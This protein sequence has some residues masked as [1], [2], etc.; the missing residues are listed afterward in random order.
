MTTTKTGGLTTRGKIVLA[1]IVVLILGVLYFSFQDKINSFAGKTKSGGVIKIGVVTWPG[2]AAGQYMNNGFEP[3]MECRFYKD[4][5]IQVQFV[6]LDDF[7]ASRKAFEAGEVDLLWCTVDA[8][9]TEM[10]RQGTMALSNPKFLFQ[11]DWSRG[12]DAIVVDLSV[13]KISDLKGKTVAVAEG[14]PSHSFLINL[15]KANNMT[16]EDIEIKP[17]PNAIDAANLFKQGTVAAAVV[18][19]PDDIDCVKKVSG[20]KVLASTKE[21]TFIIADGFIAKEEYV[22]NNLEKLQ[23]LYD[24]W[25]VGASELNANKD[26]ARD[27]AAKILADKFQMTESDALASMENV[28]YTT[29]G[30]NKNFFGLGDA[31]WVTGDLLYTSMSGEYQKIKMVENPLLWRDVSDAVL[32]KSSTLTGNGHLCEVNKKFTPV[33]EDIKNKT[34]Y[35]TK[36]VTI[37]FPTGSYTLTGEAKAKINREFVE[38]AKTNA[39]ARIRIEGN[40]DNSGNPTFNKT[41][42]EKRA[43]SVAD[44]LI[45][46]FKF[47]PNRFI[48][49]G[50]GSINAIN[51]GSKGSDEKYRTTDFEL[52]KD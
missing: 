40:T 44:Y 1:T 41:L 21:A 6:V 11:A 32:V 10:S 15:L 39:G 23:K 30:D 51:A 13:E 14:T 5:G 7:L 20:S 46:E 45:K 22:K 9:P 52:I 26:N 42:S 24:G 8:L 31:N 43:Q 35:T 25:M 38:I 3:N 27:K 17:V 18:W 49:K 34:A 19:S 28:R 4:Y 12:G 16:L 47:D 50:N 29:H 37:N 2:Y 48:V 36:K 33:T